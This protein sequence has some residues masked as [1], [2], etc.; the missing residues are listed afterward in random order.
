MSIANVEIK[1][2][3]VGLGIVKVDGVEIQDKIHKVVV[4][5]EAGQITRV[6]L[7]LVVASVK[8]EFVD[9]DVTKEKIK[10]ETPRLRAWV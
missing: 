1:L 9:C 4:V 7:T 5:A 2:S 6:Y 10:L 3:E 8:G